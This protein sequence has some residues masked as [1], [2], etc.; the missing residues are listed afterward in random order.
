MRRGR[1]KNVRIWCSLDLGTGRR[2]D[3]FMTTADNQPLNFDVKV[4]NKMGVIRIDNW[5]DEIK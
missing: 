2:R 3:L 1:F 5:K 4:Y